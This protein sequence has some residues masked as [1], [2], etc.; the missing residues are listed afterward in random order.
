VLPKWANFAYNGRGQA[1]R[2]CKGILALERAILRNDGPH[3]EGP[4]MHLW[5]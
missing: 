4:G 2:Q 1:L 3:Q 5:Q